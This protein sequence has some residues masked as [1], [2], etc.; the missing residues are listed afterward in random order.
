[1]AETNRHLF[2]GSVPF[3]ILHIDRRLI[4]IDDIFCGLNLR[5]SVS[6]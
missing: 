2:G 5:A 6:N 3:K 4:Q 1:M